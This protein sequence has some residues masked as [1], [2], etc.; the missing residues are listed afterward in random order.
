MAQSGKIELTPEGLERL[1]S[2]ARLRLSP[3]ELASTARDMKRILR[4]MGKPAAIDDS[5]PG[6]P[7]HPGREEGT[8]MRRDRAGPGLGPDE[9]LEAA[10]DADLGLFRVPKAL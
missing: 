3:E 10:P 8:P 5:R 6:S 1:S 7:A 4:Y 9:A 2:L